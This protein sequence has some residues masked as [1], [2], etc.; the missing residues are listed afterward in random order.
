MSDVLSNEDV[1]TL[2]AAK[3]ITLS[4]S[5]C[6]LKTLSK[7]ASSVTSILKNSGRLPQISSMRLIASSDELYKLSTMTTL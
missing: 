2:R 1:H 5:G 6:A 7:A 4:I 3:W